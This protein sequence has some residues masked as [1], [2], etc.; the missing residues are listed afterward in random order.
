MSLCVCFYLHL[1]FFFFGAGSLCIC[2]CKSARCLELARLKERK[3]KEEYLYSAILVCMHTLK[4]LRHGSPSFTCK[5]HHACLSFVSVHQMAPPQLRQ[6]TS[7]CNFT[8]HLSTP[9]GWKAELASK[10][11]LVSRTNVKFLGGSGI[12]TR[13]NLSDFG[14]D[15]DMR[16]F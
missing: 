7:N 9:K 3:G 12:R 6:Q 13:N 1:C 15:L 11:K 5:Q 8:T 10:Q 4:A 2:Q 16:I 14:V